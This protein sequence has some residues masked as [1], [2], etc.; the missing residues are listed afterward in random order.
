ML[1]TVESQ[2]DAEVPELPELSVTEKWHPEVLRWWE[3]VWRSPMAVEYLESDKRDL[4]LVARLEQDFWTATDSGDRQKL[5]A[6]IRQQGMRF[7]LSP[8]DRRRLQWQIEKGDQAQERTS[9]R[10]AV[11]EADPAKDPR[12]VLKLESA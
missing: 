3:S 8:I 4:F 11:K 12:D 10:R 7:G 5:A 9:K 1:P 6:E 2:A